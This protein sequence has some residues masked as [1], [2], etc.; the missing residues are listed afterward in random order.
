MY[1]NNTATTIPCETASEQENSCKTMTDILGKM[2]IPD[3]IQME[4]KANLDKKG[5]APWNDYLGDHRMG[6]RHREERKNQVTTTAEKED[7][8]DPTATVTTTT[9]TSDCKSE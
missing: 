4:K 8:T 1:E 3:I 2:E 9:F 5:P 6:T 7:K